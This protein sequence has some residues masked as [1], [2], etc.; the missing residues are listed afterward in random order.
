MYNQGSENQKA[1]CISLLIIASLRVARSVRDRARRWHAITCSGTLLSES[2][3]PIA[4][5][6]LAPCSPLISCANC[7]A[8]CDSFVYSSSPCFC[9]LMLQLGPW[10]YFKVF[11]EICLPQSEQVTLSPLFGSSF[12]FS[13]KSLLN[14]SA[15]LL[16]EILENMSSG[17]KYFVHI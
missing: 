8:V 15:S 9:F 16:L 11:A 13:S 14:L 12:G 6:A 4:C 10:L 2:S 7:F 17:S 5:K 3:N 1:V